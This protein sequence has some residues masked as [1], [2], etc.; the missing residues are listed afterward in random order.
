MKIDNKVKLG[1]I[2]A[3]LVLIALLWKFMLVSGLILLGGV[4]IHHYYNKKQRREVK[5]K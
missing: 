4:I 1:L 2:G 5:I 3:G